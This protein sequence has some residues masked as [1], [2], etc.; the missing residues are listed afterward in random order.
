MSQEVKQSNPS[1]NFQLKSLIQR[2]RVFLFF[3]SF[4]FSGLASPL[5]LNP[6]GFH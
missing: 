3:L 1:P 2:D 4:I 6:D 5:T